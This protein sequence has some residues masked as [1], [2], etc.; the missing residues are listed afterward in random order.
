MTL[1]RGEV[2]AAGWITWPSAVAMV[3]VGG[4]G[5]EKRGR[6]NEGTDESNVCAEA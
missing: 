5:G 3:G 6:Q 4:A 2:E 1:F